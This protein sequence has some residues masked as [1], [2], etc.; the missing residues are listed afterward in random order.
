MKA[1]K[2]ETKDVRGHAGSRCENP[3]K[4]RTRKYVSK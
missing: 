4:S 1:K 3:D 2:L